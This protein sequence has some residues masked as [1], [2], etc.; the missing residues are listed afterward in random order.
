MYVRQFSQN[1]PFRS[2]LQQ[3]F[4]KKDVLKKILKINSKKD[5]LKKILKINRKKYMPGPLF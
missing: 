2:S 4:N 1:S 3:A 5:V